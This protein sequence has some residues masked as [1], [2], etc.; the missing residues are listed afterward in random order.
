MRE[1]ILAMEPGRELDALVADKVMGFRVDGDICENQDFTQWNGDFLHIVSKEGNLPLPHYSTDISAAWEVVEKMKHEECSW[2]C[3]IWVN[4]DK[5]RVWFGEFEPGKD[6]LAD[7]EVPEAI[8]KA[9]LLA[10]M[11]VSE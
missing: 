8:C 11:E 5:T 1:K 2:V 6:V 7:I 9:S 4:K 3:T 10:K